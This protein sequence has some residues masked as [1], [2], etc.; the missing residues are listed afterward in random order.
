MPPSSSWTEF[1]KNLSKFIDKEHDREKLNIESVLPS[2]D[3]Q[4]PKLDKSKIKDTPQFSEK[5]ITEED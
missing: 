5:D 2:K 4:S 3:P 1:T